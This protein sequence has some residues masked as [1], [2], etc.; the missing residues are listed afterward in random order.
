MIDLAVVRIKAG[1]PLPALAW[2][3]SEALQVGDPVLTVGNGLDLGTSVSAGIVSGLN[4]NFSDSP[5]DSYIQTDAVINHGNSGGPLID[6]NGRVVGVD[7]ALINPTSSGF[8]GVGLAIPTAIA[9]FVT[10]RML[11]PHHPPPGWVGFSLQDLTPPLAEPLHAPRTAGA[12][13]SVVDPG[14][15]ASKAALRVGDVID[16]IDGHKLDDSRAFMRA[17]AIHT[18]SEVVHLSIWRGGQKQDVALTVEGWPNYKPNGGVMSGHEAAEM[19]KAMPDLG[20][21]LAALDDAERKQYGLDPAVSGVLIAHVEADSEASDLGIQAGD[22][23]LNMQGTPVTTPDDVH[24][25]V[26]Q[27][28]DKHLAWIAVL[29]RAKTGPYWIPISIGGPGS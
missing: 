16:R 9:K 17:I 10:S 5:F 18:P 28:H 7:E 6:R 13:V 20:V 22:V 15:P 1:H 24:R 3:D 23:V 11:D 8:I 19:M 2:G 4:R 21:R 14:G 25:V 26:R 12:I 27:A 29:L